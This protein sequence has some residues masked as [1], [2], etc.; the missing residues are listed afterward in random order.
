[1]NT[2]AL[3]AQLTHTLR[4]TDLPSLGTPYKGK[5]RDTYRKGDT[6]IL[7]TSDRLSAFDHVLTTL[8]F[9]G[10]VLNR[11]AA[12]WFDRTKHIV[13]NHVLDVPDPNV[14][15]ARA[16]QPFA[17][18]VV[19]RGY[20][21][22]SLWRDYEKGT[23]AAYGMPFP[24]GLRKDSAFEAPILTP[25]TKA[26]YGQHDEP[27][28]EG[29]IMSRGLATMRDWTRIKEAARGL[30]QEGQKW[31]R[32]RGLILVDTKY[33]FGKVGDELYVIDEMHTPDS[34]RYWVAD[35][36]EA[37]FAKG[38]DQKMLDKENLRQWLIRERNFS[39][40]G[41]LPSIPDD[42]RVDLATKYVAAYERITGTSLALTPGDV[43]SR[44]E[45]NLRAKGYL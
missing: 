12:F 34:S 25:A 45:E 1:M 19:V 8:P 33:E 44:I 29:A 20:L 11:L 26:E 32:T 42:V 43:H 9:K 37:R 17:V 23:L 24:L 39:G 28:S 18:E 5:V 36:Y 21:T 27:I 31:A 6:L 2:S 15:V 41:A 40:H 13:P 16:C 22:G 10:E 4:Q 14:T 30:F 3:H 7:V 38:E 35:E